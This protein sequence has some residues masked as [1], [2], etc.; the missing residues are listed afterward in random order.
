MALPLPPRSLL[1]LL[2]LPHQHRQRKRRRL[3]PRLPPAF[4]RTKKILMS[5]L[6]PSSASSLASITST[7]QKLAAPGPADA[8]PT[9]TC[10]I[11][12]TTVRLLLFQVPHAVPP[13]PPPRPSF[14]R[15]SFP[16]PQL[17]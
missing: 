10:S 4:P 16:L 13:P 3:R 11:S 9:R 2:L 1:L 17:P 6:P 8:H 12:A 15:T 14:P 5:V 7:S